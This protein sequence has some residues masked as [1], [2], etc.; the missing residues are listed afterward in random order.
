V[1]P[2]CVAGAA[3]TEILWYVY[4]YL[5]NVHERWQ[6]TS[7]IVYG[8]NWCH[9][10]LQKIMQACLP[11]GLKARDTSAGKAPFNMKFILLLNPEQPPR[12]LVHPNGPF[13]FAGT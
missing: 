13:K 12:V 9:P 11:A 6:G 7:P 1:L 4:Y 5:S 3:E 8:V 10:L 2:L